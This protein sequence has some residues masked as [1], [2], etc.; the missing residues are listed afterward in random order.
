ML[1]GTAAWNITEQ[2][3]KSLKTHA[4]WPKRQDWITDVHSP[5]PRFHPEHHHA[6]ADQRGEGGM[7]RDGI[8][9]TPI[10]VTQPSPPY[11]PSPAA[12]LPRRCDQLQRSEWTGAIVSRDDLVGGID[13]LVAIVVVR[14]VL[15]RRIE[16]AMRVVACANLIRRIHQCVR[17]GIA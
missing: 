2:E 9:P 1:S 15:G 13:E 7:G 12:R 17:H 5:L 16:R 6:N 3:R 4:R 11:S 14:I 8:Q 10:Q